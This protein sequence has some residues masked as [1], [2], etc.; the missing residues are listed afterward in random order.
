VISLLSG[1]LDSVVATWAARAEHEVVTA[2]T[3]DYGQR[4]AERET[5][6]ARRVAAKL[7]CRH[8]LVELPW[9][10]ELGGSALTDQDANM[11]EPTAGGL[12][13]PER[14]ER[15]AAAVWVPNRNGVFLNVAAA[16]AEVL[17]CDAII[18][19]FNAEEAA[20]FPDNSPEFMET[21]ERFFQFSTREGMTVLSPTVHLM[22][23]E[24]VALGEG[25]GAPL[26]DVWSCYQ[27]GETHCWRCES[28]QRLRRALNDSGS[29]V[30][31][32]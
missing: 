31:V 23:S 15:S 14:A 7:G 32:R 10:E 8:I 26:E 5:E 18:C 17:H 13:D 9:L 25:I 1:G 19:G 11:P 22:K 24:I 12:D 20:T 21:A 3:L 30:E 4:A 6:A 16:Y 27:G 29:S 28:C 2:L